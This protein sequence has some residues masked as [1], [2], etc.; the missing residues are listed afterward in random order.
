M[1]DLPVRTGLAALLA[2]LLPV[3][4]TFAATPPATASVTPMTPDVVAGYDE[5]RPQADYTR[6]VVMVPMRDGVKL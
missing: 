2:L 3:A 1:S 6:R 5:I 4:V